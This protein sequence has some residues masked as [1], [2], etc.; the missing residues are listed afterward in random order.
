M[1]S[2]PK[3]GHVGDV[4]ELHCP[5]CGATWEWTV[6]RGGK[7]FE[8]CPDCWE[9]NERKID[10][11]YARRWREAHPDRMRE[12]N[13]LSYR[14]RGGYAAIRTKM[15]SDPEFGARR[16]AA[17][18]RYFRS[19]RGSQ[20]HRNARLRRRRALHE[21]GGRMLRHCEWLATLDA[22]GHLC[23][24]CGSAEEELTRDHFVPITAGGLTTLGNIVPAC[25]RCNSIKHNTLPETFLSSERYSSIVKV[26]CKLSQS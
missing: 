10:M 3:Y 12:I 13:R 26:L 1:P 7:P 18:R 5:D 22:F 14:R 17:A 23:V 11:E 20:V 19:P 9:D 2:K 6:T 25:A 15:S 24:Y 16:R 21:Q 8:R 4:V